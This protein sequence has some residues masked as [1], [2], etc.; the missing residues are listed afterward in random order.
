MAF[1]CYSD[2]IGTAWQ[3]GTTRYDVKQDGRR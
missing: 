1:K 3:L 2:T